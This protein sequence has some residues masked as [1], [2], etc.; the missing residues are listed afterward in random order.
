M[1]IQNHPKYT[2]QL[3]FDMESIDETMLKTDELHENHILDNPNHKHDK[4]YHQY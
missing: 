2:L 4:P 1:K 3:Y